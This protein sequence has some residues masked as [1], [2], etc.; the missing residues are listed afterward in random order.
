MQGLCSRSSAL[1]GVWVP[2]EQLIR[3]HLGAFSG[4]RLR[5]VINR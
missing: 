3:A 1:P 2:A 4:T 5:C